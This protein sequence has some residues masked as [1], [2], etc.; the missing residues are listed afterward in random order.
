[1]RRRPG[2]RSEQACRGACLV[3]VSI[4]KA[5]LCPAPLGPQPFLER[6]ECAVRLQYILQSAYSRKSL[7]RLYEQAS[8]SVLL[9]AK[10]SHREAGERRQAYSSQSAP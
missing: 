6:S 10:P 5:R 7:Q 9:A 4:A 1:M 8:A 3:S 2:K